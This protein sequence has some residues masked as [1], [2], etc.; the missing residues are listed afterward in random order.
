MKDNKFLNVFRVSEEALD[1]NLVAEE[2]DS[3]TRIP[4]NRRDYEYS[5]P[6]YVYMNGGRFEYYAGCAQRKK[7]R[8][9]VKVRHG[10]CR[11]PLP[12]LLQWLNKENIK[13]DH[14]AKKVVPNRAI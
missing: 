3:D 2:K 12:L 11:N 9:G 10:S 14:M 8:T 7:F 13:L 1:A 5:E 6:G 4:G